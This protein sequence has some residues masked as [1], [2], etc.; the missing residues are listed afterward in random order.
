MPKRGTWYEDTVADIAALLYP[1][2]TIHVRTRVEGPDGGREV[3]VEIRWGTDPDRKF[4]LLECKDR[5]APVDLPEIDALHSKSIDLAP[6]L[7]ILYSNSGFTKRALRKANRLGIGAMSA[8]VR[9]SPQ[10]RYRVEYRLIA[11]LLSIDRWAL[12]VF[13]RPGDGA[14]LANWEPQDLLC[15]VPFSGSSSAQSF[16]VTV[17]GTPDREPDRSCESRWSMQGPSG[18]C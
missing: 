8:M 17:R 5:K 11:P 4:V 7:T 2:V 15:D 16:T 9:G 14:F 3:D 12:K 1:N 6:D 18:V 10:I 13:T